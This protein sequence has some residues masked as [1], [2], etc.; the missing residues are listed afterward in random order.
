MSNKL[1]VGLFLTFLAISCRTVQS[2]VELQ[3]LSEPG[4]WFQGQGYVVDSLYGVSY[5]IAFSRVAGNHY[6]FN[7][8]AVNRSNMDIM[9]DPQI[10]FYKPYQGD[11]IIDEEIYGVDPTEGLA[12][13]DNQIK[14][15]QSRRKKLSGL[16][17]AY[18]VLDIITAGI[19]R[20]N[21]KIGDDVIRDV[22]AFGGYVGLA[23]AD[24]KNA[25]ALA[26]LYQQRQAWHAG[27][28]R[29]TSLGTNEQIGGKV[30]FPVYPNAGG[31]QIYLPVDDEY[32][33]IDFNQIRTTNK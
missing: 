29:K 28:I 14:E 13:I 6:V 21:D 5:E 4:S 15:K 17:I 1:I 18:T 7:L 26:V 9:I 12:F 23:A 24:E 11:E 19:F 20:S 30:F 3:P 32:I 22:V 27:V 25:N 16:G 10:F 8:Y 2:T 33:I 31:I